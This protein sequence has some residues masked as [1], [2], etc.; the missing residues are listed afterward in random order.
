LIAWLAVAAIQTY[1]RRTYVLCVLAPVALGVVAT[2]VMLQTG[3]PGL[4]WG[5]FISFGLAA[6]IFRRRSAFAGSS[7]YKSL[8]NMEGPALAQHRGLRGPL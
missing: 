7:P 4:A 5:A 8:V 1:R 2:V 6:A 3:R